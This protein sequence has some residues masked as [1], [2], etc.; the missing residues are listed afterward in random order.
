MKVYEIFPSVQGE[1]ADV[2]LVASFVRFAGC[3]LNCRY[4]DTR[5]A[6]V[7]REE[8]S[9]EEIIR[10]LKSI[11]IPEIVVTGGEPLAQKGIADFLFKLSSAEW[12]RKIFVET[13][14][15]FFKSDIFARKVYVNISPKPPS[16]GLTF[17]LKSVESFISDF[18]DRV[19]IK[20]LVLTEED[21][22]WS[23]K[24]I[25]KHRNFFLEKGIV[26]QPIELPCEEYAVTVKRVIELIM[27]E[28]FLISE[29]NVKVVPQI[30]KLVGIK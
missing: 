3:P 5:E 8:V 19:Q 15:V 22:S 16:M 17:S 26:F 9:A 21:L 12:V 18:A 13:S 6:R 10:R 11:G 29:F 4:C 2:G 30:H 28:K 23:L 20:F 25:R 14:G 24:F 27:R 1:G 7:L